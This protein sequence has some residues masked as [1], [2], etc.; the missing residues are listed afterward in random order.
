M[1]RD[2]LGQVWTR[3]HTY[4][5]YPTKKLSKQTTSHRLLWHSPH[6]Y[7]SFVYMLLW[8][9]DSASVTETYFNSADGLDIAKLQHF[10]LKLPTL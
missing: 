4:L 10:L 9:G 5:S 3:V 8:D 2:E 7:M 6:I 1:S